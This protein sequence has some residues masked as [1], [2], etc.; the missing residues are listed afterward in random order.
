MLKMKI[1]FVE[2]LAIIR[3]YIGFINHDT[4]NSAEIVLL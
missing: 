3:I 4:D 2:V 1:S